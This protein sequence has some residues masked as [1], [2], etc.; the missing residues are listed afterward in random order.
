MKPVKIKDKLE[1]VMY[2]YAHHAHLNGPTLDIKHH[3]QNIMLFKL[4]EFLM[5]TQINAALNKEFHKELYNES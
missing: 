4:G 5:E 1:R 2:H 3:L